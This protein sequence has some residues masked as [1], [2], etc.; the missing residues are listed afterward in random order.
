MMNNEGR[1]WLSRTLG[2]KRKKRLEK[3]KKNF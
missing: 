1:D 3:E 2:R